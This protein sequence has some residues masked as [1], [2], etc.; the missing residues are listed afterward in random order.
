MARFVLLSLLLLSV[1]CLCRAEISSGGDDLQSIRYVIRRRLPSH[2]CLLGKILLLDGQYSTLG[3]GPDDIETM[4]FGYERNSGEWSK[5]A[6][7][8][9]MSVAHIRQHE[10]LSGW[11]AELFP[12]R[13][14]RR[15]YPSPITGR[16]WP[17]T[18]RQLDRAARIH[19]ASGAADAYVVL[20][21]SSEEDLQS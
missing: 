7:C 16:S 3:E 11:L 2:S 19:T 21:L 15:V 17:K 14:V 5:A 9:L 12:G 4:E 1:S 18:R 6:P 8:H 13:L 20:F 10:W